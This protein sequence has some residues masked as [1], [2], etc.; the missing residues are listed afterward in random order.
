[1]NGKHGK[2]M[3]VLY[4]KP[5]DCGGDCLYCI[6]ETT[7]T[8][9]TVPNQDTLLAASVNWSS[10]KQLIARCK[11]EDIQLGKG[12]KFELR[13]KGNSFTNYPPEY[14]EAYIKE[15]YDLL[16]GYESESFEDAFIAQKNASDKVVQIVIETRPDQITDLWCDRMRR[17]GVT[18]IE[19]GVQSLNDDV[20]SANNRGHLTDA[21]RRATELIRSYGFELG[22]QVMLG[23]YKSNPDIDADMLT[24]TLWRD[25]YY[26]DNLKVYPTLL[27]PNEEAQKPL[28]TLFHNG[29]WTPIGDAEYDAFLRSVLPSIP[30]DVHVNR[31][32][33]IFTEAEVAYG[34]SKIID[35]KK[36]RNISKCMWQRS[37][38]NSDHNYSDIDNWSYITYTHG[39][40]HSVQCVTGDGTLLGF[41]RISL[42]DGKSYIRD[43]RVL[44]DPLCIGEKGDWTNT[45]QHRGIG[46]DMLAT[47]EQ[48]AIDNGA[49]T[50][51]VYSSAGCTG[52]FEKQG[53][54]PENYY[55]L[56]KK[57]SK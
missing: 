45:L 48:L 7:V 54:L 26:P 3:T 44:G 19:I 49:D 37:F 2:Y 42:A 56:T 10:A 6:K 20:L 30:A 51:I 22:Y 46:K 41:G 24:H 31:L 14:L 50:C 13:I 52:Y 17:W 36:H 34:P 11:N 12:H 15:I 18:T 38:Q 23:L 43:L 1:M 40:H 8:R 57:L 21:V 55:T 28:Y 47:L 5:C 33:R 32:Q 4:T 25:E 53:Y 16:N 29:E 39:N 9:S 27:L 35:R